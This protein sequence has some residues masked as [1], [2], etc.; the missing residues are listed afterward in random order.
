MRYSVVAACT[1]LEVLA[2]A[3]FASIAPRVFGKLT[4]MIGAGGDLGALLDGLTEESMHAD[5]G[6]TK[7]EEKLAAKMSSL[8]VD[9]ASNAIATQFAD[10]IAWSF[11]TGELNAPK[12]TCGCSKAEEAETESDASGGSDKE[13]MPPPE[14]DHSVAEPAPKKR[15]E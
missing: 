2:R 8:A 1:G 13:N 15:K 12:W 4:E 10:R 9:P 11:A 5:D 7:A 14:P 3:G 6:M